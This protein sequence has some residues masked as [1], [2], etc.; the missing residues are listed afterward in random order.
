MHV[1][2]NETKA[3]TRRVR[4]T[5]ARSLSVQS[6][7]QMVFDKSEGRHEAADELVVLAEN[8]S[9]LRAHL[10]ALGSKAA[11]ATLIANDRARITRDDPDADVTQHRVF[12]PSQAEPFAGKEAPIVSEAHAT[13]IRRTV[14]TLNL[15]AFPLPNGKTLANA[16]HS[17]LEEAARGYGTQAKDMLH[18]STFFSALCRDLPNGKKVGDAMDNVVLT[19]IWEQTK[20]AA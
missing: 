14:K 5:G 3:P 13:R 6:I 9:E 8:N 17:D 1:E 4:A 16:R 18:K 7:I 2:P 11:V 15:L 12:R 20:L 10:V 19:N